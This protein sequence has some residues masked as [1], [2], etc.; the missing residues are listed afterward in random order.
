MSEAETGS[1]HRKFESDPKHLEPIRLECEAIARK[2][3]FDEKAVGEIGLCINEA[4][5]NVME[6]AYDFAQ[7]RP[8]EVWVEGKPGSGGGGAELMIRVRDWGP[9]VDPSKLPVKPKDP[10]V[11]GGLGLICMR[12]M[13]D[14][15]EYAPP[16]DGGMLLTLRRFHPRVRR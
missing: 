7:D 12:E 15:V 10:L 5:A 13:M 8:I 9:G 3:G 14:S 4:I 6:H 2:A 1:L 11:P 16:A